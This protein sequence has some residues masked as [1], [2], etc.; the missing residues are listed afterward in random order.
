MK[1][2][3]MIALAFTCA[4]SFFTGDIAQ[5]QMI[6]ITDNPTLVQANTGAWNGSLRQAITTLLNFALFFLGVIATAFIIFAGFLYVT[7]RGDDGQVEKA[8]NIML[9][10]AIGIIVILISFA[11]VNTLLQAGFGTRPA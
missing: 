9:Y 6:D 8:K 5:A 11:L 3:T 7:A 2:L 4:L 1:K 10:A